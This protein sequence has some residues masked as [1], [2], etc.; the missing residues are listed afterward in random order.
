MN[1][2][3]GEKIV[4][5]FYGKDSRMTYRLVESYNC[6]DCDLKKHCEENF[7]EEIDIDDFLLGP[8]FCISENTGKHKGVVYKNETT[9]M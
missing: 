1:R 2:R 8:N 6:E 5:K 9:N 3:I 4:V 7:I